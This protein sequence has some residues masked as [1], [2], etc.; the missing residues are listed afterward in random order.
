[1]IKQIFG[2]DNGLLL[3]LESDNVFLY[4]SKKS[5]PRFFAQNSTE[6]DMHLFV[7]FDTSCG[8]T[9]DKKEMDVFVPALGNTAFVLPVSVSEDDK[10][11]TGF[12]MFL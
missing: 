2:E 4:P 12:S 11:F 9:M 6:Y 3:Q 7:S 5:K 8:I 10:M 1:M